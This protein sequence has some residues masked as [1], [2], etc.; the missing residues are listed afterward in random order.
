MRTAW[1]NGVEV[2]SSSDT[3]PFRGHVYFPP[4][5]V[6]WEHL[7]ERGHTRWRWRVG[8]ACLLCLAVDDVL[9]PDGAWYYPSPRW[10]LGH[11]TDHVAFCEAVA[12]I[13]DDRVM[14]G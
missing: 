10:G 9:L 11:L 12:I 14:R 5:T 6:R 2:A 8:T 13:D 3:I 7:V 4:D 1:W